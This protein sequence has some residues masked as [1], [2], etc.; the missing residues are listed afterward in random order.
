MAKSF[1]KG[2]LVWIQDT[3]GAR[4]WAGRDKILQDGVGKKELD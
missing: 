1:Q 2:A 3:E 4:A